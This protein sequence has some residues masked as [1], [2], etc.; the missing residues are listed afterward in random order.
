M[1]LG[2]SKKA[3]NLQPS[4]TLA[5]T[6]RAKEMKRDGKPVISFGS[7]E[8]DFNSPQAVVDAARDAIAKGYTHYTANN[9]IPELR[10]AVCAY[11]KKHFNLDYSASEVLVG[12]GAKPILYCALAAILDEGDEVIV[13]APAWVSY[14]EQIRLC[15]GK[16]VLVECGDTNNVPCL[17]RI[18]A[19]VTSKTKCIMLNSPNN[20]SGAVYDEEIMKGIAQ[21]ALDN[22]LIILNDEIYERLVYGD[23]KFVQIVS[24]C[25]A[26]K[27][28]V[29]N[30]NGVSK[31]F[32]MTGWR[33][34][35][36]VGPAKYIK[37]MGSIQ[38]HLTSNACS[39]AQ[40][41]AVGGLTGADDT[42]VETMRKAF[43]ARRDL[44]FSMLD[45]IPQISYVKPNGAFYVL[46]DLKKLLGKKH[47]GKVLTDD[48]V[49]CADLLEK[50][51]V[52][53][54]PGS[55]FFANGTMRIAYSN[56]ED[57]IREGLNRVA[58]YIAEIQ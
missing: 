21:I 14:V 52:A 5:V 20:P 39:V 56:S 19:A 55:A 57:E 42:D 11:Y 13:L 58:E 31:A 4:A 25:P 6:A 30:I 36:G 3:L 33:I 48:A 34:G 38:G 37:A 32:A 16:E 47:D 10:E 49:F 24:A 2:L 50:K 8:P 35:Y 23:T 44:V 46:V 9:G 28:R 17:D 53:I 18:K 15:G 26:V 27:D 43:S 40:Y 7:G 45:K 54:T 12:S 29:I 51:Y 41:A 1:S 22:D